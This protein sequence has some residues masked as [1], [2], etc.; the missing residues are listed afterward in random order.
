MRQTR[1]STAGQRTEKLVI[2]KRAENHR[3]P[4]TSN[5]GLTCFMEFLSLASTNSSHPKPINIFKNGPERK[6]RQRTQWDNCHCKIANG[7]C[8]N[9]SARLFAGIY[10]D[11]FCFPGTS[12]WPPQVITPADPQKTER[13]LEYVRGKGYVISMHY[14]EGGGAADDWPRINHLLFDY[15]T[16]AYYVC[17]NSS[18]AI[19]LIG[20]FPRACQVIGGAKKT[21]SQSSETGLEFIGLRTHISFTNSGKKLKL[22]K[23]TGDLTWGFFWFLLSFLIPSWESFS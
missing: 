19:T 21:A 1:Q 20:L 7:S 4:L 15:R 14:G 10:Q 6:M 22:T 2:A 3:T 12:T 18:S 9:K 16:P 23:I 17:N 8:D 13:G 5:S 11:I